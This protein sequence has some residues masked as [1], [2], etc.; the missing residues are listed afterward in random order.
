MNPQLMRQLEN[1]VDGLT[2]MKKGMVTEV[3]CGFGYVTMDLFLKKFDEV[4]MFDICPV[5]IDHVKQKFKNQR[6]VTSI[7]QMSMETYEW[8]TE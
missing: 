3:A 6:K 8:N 1:F 7:K 2:S 5:S 4:Q